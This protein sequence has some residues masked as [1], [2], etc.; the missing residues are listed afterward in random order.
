MAKKGLTSSGLATAGYVERPGAQINWGEIGAQISDVLTAEAKSR[1]EKKA[2][3]REESRKASM[4]LNNAPKGQSEFW[5]GVTSDYVS[6]AQ[7]QM[8]MTKRLLE[9]GQMDLRDYNNIRKNMTDGTALL[10]ENVQKIQDYVAVHGERMQ[11]GGK[12]GREA[13]NAEAMVMSALGIYGDDVSKTTITIDNMSGV[14]GLGRLDEKGNLITDPGLNGPLT[15]EQMTDGLNTFVDKYKMDDEMAAAEKQ[16]GEKVISTVVNVDGSRLKAVEKVTDKTMLSDEDKVLYDF[17]EFEE[18]M[19]NANLSDPMKMLSVLTDYSG[20]K[21][22]FCFTGDC[23][24]GNKIEVDRSKGY[25]EYK[26]SDG[27]KARAFDIMQRNFRSKIGYKRETER[28]TE[29]SRPPQRTAV[30]ISAGEKAKMQADLAKQ[31]ARIRTAETPQDAGRIFQSIFNNPFVKDQ[32]KINRT[33]PELDANNKLVGFRVEYLDNRADTPISITDDIL[34]D[35]EKWMEVGTFVHGMTADEA[36]KKAGNEGM[37][38]TYLTDWSKVK[39]ERRGDVDKKS[40]VMDKYIRGQLGITED[41]FTNSR[42][43]VFRKVQTAFASLPNFDVNE[44]Y[45]AIKIVNTETG[46]EIKL[47][48]GVDSE[49]AKQ[50]Y[51]TL[52]D[53][54]NANLTSA[55]AESIYNDK[56][57]DEF[58]DRDEGSPTE[59]KTEEDVDASGY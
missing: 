17:V 4:A 14:V 45:G 53:L 15:M 40:V 43:N 13:S 35:R 18:N 38:E 34:A 20:E 19:I 47:K 46:K 2:A 23:A 21:Y 30:E 9:G 32:L 51:N 24:G 41:L 36:I 31:W 27:Q 59:E 56:N 54:I 58:F 48:T 7:Q 33:I 12:D 29:P 22:E 1:E 26:F 16:L 44:S 39:G 49:Q 3:I 52:I 6:N 11:P 57:L 5:N 10:F 28:V 55:R 50:E 37:G 8:L 25:T 42:E